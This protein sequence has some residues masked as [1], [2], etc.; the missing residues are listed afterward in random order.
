MS[1]IGIYPGTFDPMTN[2]HLNIIQRSL[3][4]VDKLI[5]GVAD[6]LNKK[7]LLSID[8]R[9]NI[10][11]NDI[12]SLQQNNKNI[13]IHTVNGLLTEFAKNVKQIVLLEG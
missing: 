4:V 2:G 8:E 1:K 6:N 13:E 10:I 12:Y 11:T 3:K 5:I 9:K 7:P